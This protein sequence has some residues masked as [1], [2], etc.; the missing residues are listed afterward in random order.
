MSSPLRR[1]RSA[2]RLLID[3]PEAERAS[4]RRRLD[5]FDGDRIAEPVRR[6][7]ADKSAAGLVKA[8]IFV[9]D[10]ARRN[11]T[12]RAG[13]VEF[14]KQSGARHPGNVPVENR[15]DAV[16]QEMRDQPIGG[17]ALGL[18]GPA[19]G[20]R[21]VC[22]DLGEAAR[23]RSIRQAVGPEFERSDQRA[24][25]NKIGI[26]ADRRSEMRVAAQIEPEMAEILR[27][28][29]RLR[30]RAQHH[31]IDQP[32][33]VAALHARQNAI[34][35]IGAKRSAFRQRDVEGG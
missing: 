14:D 11:E 18:H 23:I 29:L 17:F 10:G 3:E 6:R 19:F 32:F 4:N 2:A 28:I 30:L 25:D 22:R 12:V 34:E 33:D 9:A 35:A 1:T 7:A 31:F 15:A 5:E 20:G 27:R 16:G 26:A 8:K 13:F 21:N 24:M